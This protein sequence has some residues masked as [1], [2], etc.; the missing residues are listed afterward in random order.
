MLRHKFDPILSHISNKN[1]S[2]LITLTATWT[3]YVWHGSDGVYLRQV[4]FSVS[5][6]SLEGARNGQVFIVNEAIL[7]EGTFNLVSIFEGEGTITICLKL[8]NP[9]FEYITV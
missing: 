8:L 6:L 2:L 9:A 4:H 3:I 5:Y 1:I 7:G